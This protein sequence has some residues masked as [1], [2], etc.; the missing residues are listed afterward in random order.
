MKI[1][2]R[3]ALLIAVISIA[4]PNLFAQNLKPYILG[5]E[6][7]EKVSDL[8]TT[9]KSTMEKSGLQVVGQYQPAGDVNRWIMVFSSSELQGAVRQIGGLTG[10]AATLRLGITSENGKTLVTYTNPT[11]W[12]NAYFR[13]DFDKV[14]SAYSKISGKIVTAMKSSGTY[15]GTSFGSEK[16]VSVEDLRKYHYMM[17][18]PYFD[19][20]VELEDFDSY[21]SAISKIESSIKKGVPNVKQVYKVSIEGQ[22]LTLYGFALSGED[23]EGKFL[24]TIDITNPKHTAFLPY[25]VLVKGNEVLM[26][27]GRFRIALSF[28]DLTMGTF[29]KIMSTPGNI[30]DLLE[31]LVEED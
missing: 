24:P 23:G 6:S 8:K 21:Q 16:G 12:G 27:H 30:E 10:F 29:T 5:I 14:A 1:N 9:I 17:G 25:E 2:V 7:S 31:Q 28:P 11:Y 22:Q 20:P 13:D 3:I 18:M 19:D 26:L 15:I 4:S